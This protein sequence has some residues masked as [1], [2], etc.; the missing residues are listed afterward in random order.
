MASSIQVM[1]MCNAFVANG[2]EVILF[3]PDR[4]E[5]QHS[6]VNDIYSFYNV[7]NIFTITRIFF[8]KRIRLF[9]NKLFY[10]L[11]IIKNLKKLN[12]DLVYGR[13]VIGCALAAFLGYRVKIELHNKL[14]NI[15][16]KLFFRLMIKSKKVENFI[17][18]TH[19]LKN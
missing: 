15:L 16:D 2:H 10:S 9:P 6:N 4:P 8:K 14:P 17:F 3:V 11:L 5:R 7:S 1:K 12:P 19:K 18:I 13:V